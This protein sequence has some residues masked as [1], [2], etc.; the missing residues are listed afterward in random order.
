MVPNDELETDQN[1]RKAVSSENSI[2]SIAR[3]AGIRSKALAVF[4]WP[5]EHY[6]RGLNRIKIE[7]F[8]V[9]RKEYPHNLNIIEKSG[10]GHNNEL[11]TEYWRHVV[12]EMRTVFSELPRDFLRVEPFCGAVAP[13][14]LP[15][16]K[17]EVKSNLKFLE[18]NMNQTDVREILVEDF[19]GRP[20]VISN[21]FKTSFVRIQHL[22]HYIQYEIKTTYLLRD[23]GSVVEWG[24]GYGDAA[25][26]YLKIR[27]D[28]TYSIIDLPIMS[29][30]QYSYLSSIF[31]DSMVNLVVN[32]KQDVK[33][34]AI[35]LIPLCFA[36]SVQIE[37]E[38][39]IST[40]ALTET[41][42]ATIDFIINHKMFGAQHFLFAYQTQN[43]LIPQGRILG[44]D[45]AR[46]TG[47]KIM[48][49]G[50]EDASYYA[51]R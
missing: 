46:V 1:Q 6:L 14:V 44:E 36:S 40:F 41:N 22:C 8:E 20:Y 25:R 48:K 43:A 29:A 26:L 18:D 30:I 13:N 49:M 47:S 32:E 33:H 38:M 34:H 15:F 42:R 51:F 7:K 24:G 28:T 35:N 10:F 12:Q 37:A 16:T 3:R 21:R 5:K 27:P 2:M 50:R 4:S 39:L 9:K 11:L 23:I 17:S 19:V 45:I 31:P